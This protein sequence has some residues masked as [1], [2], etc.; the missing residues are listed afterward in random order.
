MSQL[1]LSKKC[2]EGWVRIGQK[3][4]YYVICANTSKCGKRDQIDLAH[5]KFTEFDNIL[6]TRRCQLC[7]MRL[8]LSRADIAKHTNLKYI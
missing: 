5:P 4:H 7:L 2:D 6:R 1:T 3:F 8:G